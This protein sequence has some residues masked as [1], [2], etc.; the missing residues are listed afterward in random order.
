MVNMILMLTVKTPLRPLRGRGLHFYVSIITLLLLYSS[1][2][3]CRREPSLVIYNYITCHASLTLKLTECISVA[4]KYMKQYVT[5][6]LQYF[7][8]TK[9]SLLKELLPRARE[10][11][12]FCK[13]LKSNFL[14]TTLNVSSFKFAL[15][16]CTDYD[17]LSYCLCTALCAICCKY[18][19]NFYAIF[20][21][22]PDLFLIL[23]ENSHI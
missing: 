20:L 18:G 2:K 23:F 7:C 22:G 3:Q 4:R 16:A 8:A 6:H 10:Q 11:I 17:F 1:Q 15:S 5:H 19:T 13:K 14:C 12:C 9:A 21:A